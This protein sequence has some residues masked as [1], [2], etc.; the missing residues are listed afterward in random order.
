[1]SKDATPS[2]QHPLDKFTTLESLHDAG[3]SAQRSSPAGAAD[4]GACSVFA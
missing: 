3:A 1:L 4:E 2:I